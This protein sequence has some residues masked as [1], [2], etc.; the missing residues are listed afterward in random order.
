[1]SD[2]IPLYDPLDSEPEPEPEPIQPSPEA[3]D[4]VSPLVIAGALLALVALVAGAWWVFL[5]A[6]A[7]DPSDEPAAVASQS[8]ATS[9]S[10]EPSA[11]GDDA[12]DDPAAAPRLPLPPLDASDARVRDEVGGLSSRAEWVDWLAPEDLVRRFVASVA[13]VAAGESPRAHAQ[14]LAPE[15]SFQTVEI[16]DR[17]SIDSASYRRYD[18]AADVFAS[19]DIGAA[20]A[21]YHDMEPLFEEAYAEIGDP[22]QTFRDTLATAL[23]RLIAVEVPDEDV[24][25]VRH[26]THYKFA[27]PELEALSPAAKHLLR[28]GPTNAEKVQQ[29]LRFLRSALDL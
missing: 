28:M 14:H 29:K 9:A 8:L 1:M 23:D 15:A 10:P 4:G 6:P 7:G 11:P 12:S 16:G 17:V 18:L 27:D 22:R 13:N 25:L 5:R 19:L 2:E 26:A 3:R 21:L 24:A 20:V